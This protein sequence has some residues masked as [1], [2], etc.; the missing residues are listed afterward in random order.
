MCGMGADSYAD[1]LERLFAAFE[2]VHTF[3]VIEEVAARCKDDLAGQTS[4]NAQLELIERLARHRLT[5][6]PSTRHG[7]T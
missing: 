1:L 4:H 5:D 6:L 3:T 2:T 7:L